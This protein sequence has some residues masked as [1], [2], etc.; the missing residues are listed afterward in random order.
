M[1]VPIDVIRQVPLFTRLSDKELKTLANNFTER[2]FQAGQ[3]LTSEGQGAAGFFV[4]ESGQAAVSVD[5]EVRRTLGTGDYF[6]EVALIDDGP[7]TATVTAATDVTAYVLTPWEFRPLVEESA[8]IAWELLQVMAKRLRRRK[9]SNNSSLWNLPP[10]R[11]VTD[12]HGRSSEQMVSICRRP[13]RPAR[14][15]PAV[16]GVMIHR[17]PTQGGNA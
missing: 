1:A 8:G 4:I 15:F 3:E 14:K 9:I 16:F 7:R 17:R 13:Y 6:G 11:F 12:W 5:G 2:A 10:H